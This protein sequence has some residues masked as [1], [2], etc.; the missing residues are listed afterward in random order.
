MAASKP[1]RR[2]YRTGSVFLPPNAK[3]WILQIYVNGKRH[4][5]STGKQTKREAELV[6]KERMKKFENGLSIEAAKLTINDLMDAKLTANSNNDMAS[7][8]DDEARWRLHSQPY[9]GGMKA[10]NVTTIH[11]QKY[12][13]QR[14]KE[15][16]VIST[17]IKK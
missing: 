6:L 14:L 2:Q 16:I 5:E 11:I 10:A 13:A 8:A 12:T 4:R 7:K 1:S 15:E 9:F 3:T 17:K